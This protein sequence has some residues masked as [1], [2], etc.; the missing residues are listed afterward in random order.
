MAGSVGVKIAVGTDER[1]KKHLVKVAE[2]TGRHTTR[3]S[4]RAGCREE[5][6]RTAERTAKKA[7]KTWA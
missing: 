5:G 4:T 7:F 3:I 1:G 2:P 6:S